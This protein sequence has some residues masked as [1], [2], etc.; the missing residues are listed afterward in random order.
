MANKTV[1]DQTAPRKIILVNREPAMVQTS[2]QISA[3]SSEHFC[4]HTISLE[5]DKVQM[6]NQT[7]GLNSLYTHVLGKILP[8]CYK[9]SYHM[10]LT[11]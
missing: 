9:H 6:E 3:V 4:L 7:Y 8:L 11:N 1:E 2:L 5:V 10:C